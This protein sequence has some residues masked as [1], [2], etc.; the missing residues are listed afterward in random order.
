MGK[1]GLYLED[2]YVMPAFRGQG[3]AKKLLAFLAKLAIERDCG[4]LEWW[5]VDW[6]KKAIDFYLNM[7]AVA[8]D[9]WTVYRVTDEKLQQLAEQ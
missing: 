6:N 7:G 8:M 5:V 3:V 4:R 1:P 9:E 2:L